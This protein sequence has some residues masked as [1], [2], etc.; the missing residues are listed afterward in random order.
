MV[1][2]RL[3]TVWGPVLPTNFQ[4][5]LLKEGW[6]VAK[7]RCD[8]YTHLSLWVCSVQWAAERSCAMELILCQ[9]SSNKSSVLQINTICFAKKNST[10]KQIQSDLQIQNSIWEKIQS[11]NCE[12]I[13]RSSDFI[14]QNCEFIA[15][16][17]DFL[18]HN[19][20]FISHNYEKK[21]QNCSEIKS[22]NYLFIFL[23]SGRNGLP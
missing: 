14:C 8:A 18:T 20:E 12:F 7:W 23:F 22:C 10:F 2:F 13:S 1:S 21:S 17:S 19:C 9:Y 15:H 3:M 11:R 5:K 16:N 4:G 6:Y